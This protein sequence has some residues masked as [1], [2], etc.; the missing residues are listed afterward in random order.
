MGV[1]RDVASHAADDF[2]DAIRDGDRRAFD[3]QVEQWVHR[4]YDVALG[5]LGSTAA[6]A[7]VGRET[8]ESLWDRH[9]DLSVDDLTRDSLLIA[10][11]S[12]GT[13]TPGA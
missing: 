4:I 13:R 2:L 1:P 9:H 10:T 7:E 11:R 5:I 3:A 6:A 8:I 12:A